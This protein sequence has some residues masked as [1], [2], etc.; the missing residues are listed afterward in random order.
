[1]SDVP[2][3]QLLHVMFSSEL[4]G[5][6]DIAFKDIDKLDNAEMRYFIVHMHRPLDPQ[7]GAQH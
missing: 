3:K 2:A 1:M 7:T 5:V 4:E 6:S